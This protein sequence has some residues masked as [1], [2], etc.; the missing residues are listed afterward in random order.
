MEWGRITVPLAGFAADSKVLEAGAAIAARL[1]AEV[2]AVFAPA[3]PAELTPWLGEGFVGGV[4]VAA[5]ESL[6]EAAAEGEK[7]ARAA[8]DALA[9]PKKSFTVLSSPVWQG[10]ATE[11][12]LSD[13][14]VAGDEDG[15]GK[16]PLSEAFQQILMEERAAVWVA[17]G[18]VDLSG[19]VVVAWDGGEPASRAARRASPLLRHASRVVVAGAPVGD[20]P[21]PLERLQAYYA[22][23]GIASEVRALTRGADPAVSLR[24][25]C[26]EVG[27]AYM[28]AGAFGRSRLREF[29]FGGTTRALLQGEGPSLF[30]AH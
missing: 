15:R 22:A 25:L 27:A 20:R 23:K 30:M 19:T 10:L 24:E 7:I 6:K 14:I 26:A 21:C 1:D 18:P 2:N 16:G 13:L 12:R 9:Y 8:F 5:I 17:R 29:V 4:Q 3:D 11:A 28:V